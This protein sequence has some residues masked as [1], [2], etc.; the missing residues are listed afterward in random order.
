MKERKE[1]TTEEVCRVLLT[2]EDKLEGLILLKSHIEKF[3]ETKEKIWGTFGIAAIL[4]Q[5]ISSSYMYFHTFLI[6]TLPNTLFLSIEILIEMCSIKRFIETCVSAQIP[7]FLYP[8]LNSP[9]QGEPMEQIKMKCL[10]FI[11]ILLND[12][13][14]ENKSVEFFKNTELVPLCLR[15]MELGSK[16]SKLAAA[17]V[18]YSIITTKEGLEYTCQT[19]D[20]FMATSMILNSVLVQ[21]EGLNCPELLELIIK[22]YTQLC[23][24]PNAKVVFSKNRPQT[25]YA[26]HIRE[27]VRGNPS[28][29][30][31]YEEF[32]STLQN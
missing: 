14:T 31:A 23:G 28:V 20:R 8:I 3:P 19:Y 10:N 25:L 9:A 18:F 13:A 24:M 17:Q 1:E 30:L 22:I 12:K 2:S 5:E 7:L 27:M 4:L 29:K 15:N 21:M 32:L 26:E 6:N 16:K 11:K